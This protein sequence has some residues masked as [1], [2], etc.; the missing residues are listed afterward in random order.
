MNHLD[1]VRLL[2]FDASA[3]PEDEC[4]QVVPGD[5]EFLVRAVPA[6]VFAGS[7]LLERPDAVPVRSLEEFIRPTSMRIGDMELSL[8]SR[9]QRL[10]LPLHPESGGM[11]PWGRSATDGVLLWDTTADWTTVV[12]DDDFQLWLDLPFSASE[13]VGRALLGRPEGVPAFESIEEYESGSFWRVADDM[14]ATA[15]ALSNPDIG[16]VEEL[17]ARI[18]N[19]GVPG[20]RQYAR[21]LVDGAAEN[22][23]TPDLV[24]PEDYLAVMREFPGGVIAGTRVF[25]VAEAAWLTEEPVFRQWG[26]L[27]GRAF[28]WLALTAD[29]QEWRVACIEPGGTSLTHLE[30]Q[31]FASFLRRRLRGDDSLF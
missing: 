29:P 26:E 15:T 17:V 25:P 19:I 10:W 7:V 4:G 11:V 16:A 31:T 24:F 23:K 18:R 21:E 14:R 27:E 9:D 28:G 12:T 13:F 20:I 2:G 22:T 8:R 1:V 30:E 5:F 3:R 6:G